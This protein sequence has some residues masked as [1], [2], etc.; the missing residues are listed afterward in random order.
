MVIEFAHL[1]AVT[2]SEQVLT[3]GGDT[4]DMVNYVADR[5]HRAT[6]RFVAQIGNLFD[7]VQDSVTELFLS[8]GVGKQWLEVLQAVCNIVAV[9]WNNVFVEFLCP[10]TQMYYK[11][12]AEVINAFSIILEIPGFPARD[13]LKNMNNGIQTIADVV[14]ADHLC[15]NKKFTCSAPLRNASQS[16]QQQTLPTPTRCW[17]TYLTFFGDNQQLSCTAADTCRKCYAVRRCAHKA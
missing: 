8:R 9:L 16:F 5:L 12:L 3:W 13:A 6:M 2:A 14:T 17:S 1:V 7:I 10:F 11:F 15:K 4:S